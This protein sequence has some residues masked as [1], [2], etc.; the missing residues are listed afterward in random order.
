MLAASTTRC[1]WER[2]LTN[3]MLLGLVCLIAGMEVLPTGGHT[4]ERVVLLTFFLPSLVLIVLR[5][6]STRI[7][8]QQPSARWVLL[9]LAWSMLSLV[10]SDGGSV[11]NWVG[12]CLG[13][14]LFLYGWQQAFAG[15]EESIHRLLLACSIVLALA[16]VVLV[17]LVQMPEFH[18]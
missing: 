18:S 12:R 11:S 4:Y 9:L 5:P 15:R 17:A 14:M 7:L 1:G 6:S 2:G 13:I 16:A 8:W 10:W 3:V